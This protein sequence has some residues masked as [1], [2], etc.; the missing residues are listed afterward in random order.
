VDDI[1]IP[2]LTIG[3]LAR[4]T[5]LAVR[6]IRY[7]SDIGAVPPT[8]AGYRLDDGA[9]AARLELARTLRELGLGLDDVRRML[10]NEATVAEVGTSRRSTRRSDPCASREQC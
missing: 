9:T 8:P 2:P 4:H 10:A 3:Q 6:T 1:E 7:W 5:G